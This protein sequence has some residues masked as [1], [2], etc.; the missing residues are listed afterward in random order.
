M[1]KINLNKRTRKRWKRIISFTMAVVMC[2]EVLPLTDL[3]GDLNITSRTAYAYDSSTSETVSIGTVAEFVKY[4]N[5]YESGQHN[6]NDTLVI[7]FGSDST[8]GEFKNGS[9]TYKSIGS[10]RP[11]DGKIIIQETP[12]FTLPCAMFDTITDDVE[13]VDNTGNETTVCLAR[14]ART[15]DEPLFAKHV[16][17]SRTSG[18]TVEWNFKYTGFKE[19]ADDTNSYVFDFAGYIG[20]LGDDL[21][22]GAKVKIGKITHDNLGTNGIANVSATGDAGLV[23]C[24]VKA[25]SELE[26]GEIE[27]TINGTTYNAENNRSSGS[28]TVKSTSSGNAGGLVGSMGVGSTLTLGTALVNHQNSGMDISVTDGYAGG[29]VGFCDDGLITYNNS[30]A[31]TVTQKLTGTDGVGGIAGYFKASSGGTISTGKVS[32]ASG[33]KVNGTGNCGGL[34][35]ELVNGGTM[36][37]SAATAVTSDHNGGAAANLGGLVGKYMAS[38][39]SNTLTVDSSATIT[40]TRSA[41]SADYYGGAIGYLDSADTTNTHSA[42]VKFNGITVSAG[43]IGG[44]T[45]NGYF[46]GL[47]GG[48]PYSFVDLA[49]TN[50]ISYSGISGARNF[51]GIVG[52]LSEG[53]LRLD[54]T[55]NLS[56]AADSS[57]YTAKS[58]QIVGYR[59]CGL[60]YA[61]SDWT[62]TRPSS[63]R[64]LDDVGSWGEVLNC[65]DKL[66]LSKLFTNNNTIGTDHYVTL[67]DA[68]T[69]IKDK[70]DFAKTALNIQLNNGQSTGVLQCSSDSTSATLLASDSLQLEKN[71]TNIELDGTGITGFT[72]DNGADADTAYLTF[73]GTFDG[74]GGTIKLAVGNG[75]YNDYIYRH[76]YNGL[77]AKTSG[78]STIEDLVISGSSVIN[79]RELAGGMNVGNIIAKASGGLTLS[80]VTI[81]SGATI[82]HA[83]TTNS[84]NIG[85]LIGDVT[86][87]GT[88]TISGCEYSGTIT[89]DSSNKDNGSGANIGGLIG[90]VDSNTFTI[91]LTDTDLKGTVASTHTRTEHHI[92]G[93]IGVIKTNANASSGR[94]VNITN[95]KTDGLSVSANGDCGGLL[96]YGWYK[97]D[98]EFVTSNG[99]KVGSTTAPTITNTGTSAAGLCLIATGYWKVNTGGIDID[100]I[101]V[102]ANSATSFGLIINQGYYKQKDETWGDPSS[103]LSSAIYLELAPNAFTV[104]GDTLTLTPATVAVFDELVA[105]TGPDNNVLAN[106]Q[107]V[108]S[109]ATASHALLKMDD[110]NTGVTYQH[111][112]A[113]AGTNASKQY[114]PHSRY[115]YNLDSYRTSPSGNEQNFLMWSVKEY[116]HPSIKDYFSSSYTDTIGSASTDVFNM[117][118]YSYY[119]VDINS[120]KSITIKGK[121][122]LYNTEFNTT[123]NG[124]G[125]KRSSLD[126]TTQHYT[127]HNALFRN[128]NGSLTVQDTELYGKVNVDYTDT[129]AGA[130]VMGTVWSDASG[131]PATVTIKS[132]KLAGIEV[133]NL[134]ATKHSGSGTYTYAPLLI[135]KAG[136]NATITFKNDT[137]G[138]PSIEN[139]SAYSSM[140]AGATTP[141]YIASSL[142]GKMGSTSVQK[143]RLSFEDIKLDGRNSTGVTNLSGL[144]TTY[145][146]KGCLFKEAILLEE[147]CYGDNSGSQGTYNFTYEVD[148]NDSG[149][150]SRCVTYGYEIEGSVE[151][152][153]AQHWYKD[154]WA[155]STTPRYV[156]PDNK[157]NVDS[158]YTDFSTEFMNYVK[159][160]SG[161]TTGYKASENTHELRVNIKA[162]TFSGCGTYND[163]YIITDA[164]DFA[165]IEAIIDGSSTG[166]TIKVPTEITNDNHTATWCSDKTDNSGH[167]VYTTKTVNSTTERTLNTWS[168]AGGTRTITDDTL[169]QYLAGAYY[170]I[171]A[172]SDITI[173]S[174]FTGLSND[175]EAP[176]VFRGVIDGSG[177]TIKTQSAYPLISSSN[178]SV[179]YNLT[180]DVQ[181]TTA[182]KLIETNSKPFVSKGN[183]NSDRC[184][185]YGAVIGQ[186]LGGDNIIDSVSVKFTGQ[187]LDADSK[188]KAQLVPIGGYVGVVVNGGLIFRGVDGTA[189]NNQAGISASNLTN[190]SGGTGGVTSSANTK[191]LYVNPI[192][193]RVLNGYAVTESTSYKP[194]EDGKRKYGDGSGV[195]FDGSSFTE[196]DDIDNYSGTTV[197]VTMRNGT[198][199]YSITDISTSESKLNVTSGRKITADSA[200]AFF[201]MSVIVNS[202]IGM[203]DWNLNGSSLHD[204]GSSTAHT[205]ANGSKSAYD[206]TTTKP[207]MGYY[208]D[209]CMTHHSD[210][211]NIGTAPNTSDPSYTTVNTWDKSGVTSTP[212]IVKKYTVENSE[213]S[214]YYAK[215]IAYSNNTTEITINSGKASNVVYYLP[216]GYKGIGN[217][218][219]AIRYDY[220]D[221]PSG[222]PKTL[223]YYSLYQDLFLYASKFTGYGATISQNTSV[224]YYHKSK[225]L[226][227]Y[228]GAFSDFQTLKD[229]G[230][231]K[232]NNSNASLNAA[233]KVNRTGVGLFNYQPQSA[234]IEKLHLTGNV[235]TDIIQTDGNPYPYTTA[236]YKV[237]TSEW[238]LS[239]GSLIGSASVDQTIK[240]V[241]INNI[242]VEGPKY[243]GGMIGNLP[244]GKITLS[245]DEGYD[246][247][248][249]RVHGGAVTG[250]LIGRNYAG[251][252]TFNFNNKKVDLVEV[253]SRFE[254]I[255]N[256]GLTLND[257]NFYNYGLGGLIGTCRAANNKITLYNANIGSTDQSALSIISCEKA[258]IYT[259]GM[260]G[261]LNRAYLDMQ[262]CTVYNLSIDSNFAAGGIAGHWATSGNTGVSRASNAGKTSIISNVSVVCTLPDATIKSTG[263][264]TK[265]AE[266]KFCTAGGFIGSGKEDMFDVTIQNSNISKYTIEGYGY[267][268]GFVGSWGDNSTYGG[269]GFNDHI[270]ILKNDAI[271]NCMVESKSTT[272]SAGGLLGNLN[273]GHGHDKIGTAPAQDSNNK[274]Y[275]TAANYYLYGYNI[276]TEDVNVIGTNKGAVCGRNGHAPANCIKIAGFTRQGSNAK[277]TENVV[278]KA[279]TATWTSASAVSYANNDN[280]FGTDADSKNGYVVFADYNNAGNK[281]TGTDAEDNPV[282]ANRQ[283]LFSNVLASGSKSNVAYSDRTVDG[284]NVSDNW[285]YVTSSP[286][287]DISNTQYLTSDGAHDSS[288]VGSTAKTILDDMNSAK[289]KRYQN[290][291]FV[292][293]ATEGSDYVNLRDFLTGGMSSFTRHT[294]TGYDGTDFPILVVSNINCN[295]VLTNYLRLLSN[296]NFNYGTDDT[297]NVFNVDISSWKYEGGVFTQ[298]TG[299]DVEPALKRNP[300][301]KGFYITSSEFDNTDYQFSLIDVQYLDPSDTSKIAYHLYVP[302]VVKKMLH[303]NVNIRMSS[304]TTYD[305]DTY[306]SSVYNI[307]EN[308]GNPVT[309]KASFVYIRDK[310]EW[311]AAINEGESVYRNYDGSRK[312]LMFTPSATLFPEGAEIVLLD[313]N[314]DK[315]KSYYGKFAAAT[316]TA[317]EGQDPVYS[318]TNGLMEPAGD[319]IYK[320][321]LSSF[322]GF[323]VCKLNDM[324]TISLDSEATEKNLVIDNSAPDN[325]VVAVINDGSG[326]NGD[327]LRVAEAGDSEGSKVAIKVTSLQD[328]KS[329]IEETYYL[330]IFTKSSTTTNI[331]HYQINGVSDF[332]EQAYPSA[333][334][335][336]EAPHLFLGNIYSNTLTLSETNENDEMSKT[337]TAIGADLVAKVGFTPSAIDAGITGF[338]GNPNVQIFQTFLVSLNMVEKDGNTITNKRGIQ[339]DPACVAS[340]YKLT[341]RNASGI[342]GVLDNN[343]SHLLGCRVSGSYVEILND[344]NLKNDLINAARHP[345]I[346]G[347][348]RDYTV[349]IESSISLTY[350]PTMMSVQFPK[351]SRG[352]GVGT[353]MIGYSNISS[354]STN[355]TASRASVNTETIQTEKSEPLY[356]YLYFMSEI[357]SVDFS[358]KAIEND[359]YLAPNGKYYPVAGKNGNYGQLGIDANQLEGNDTTM[360][361]DTAAYYD[362]SGYSLKS[363]GHYLKIVVQLS[364][365]ADYSQA[366]YIPTYLNN[367]ELYDKDDDD[368][369]STDAGRDITVT[370]PAEE[371][372]DYLYTYIIPIEELDG[373]NDSYVIPIS[374]DV[375][376][377]ANSGFESKT[378]KDMQYSNYRVTVTVGMLETSTGSYLTNSDATDWVVYTNARLISDVIETN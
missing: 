247:D 225:D 228:Y 142:L 61:E 172:S 308:L 356:R 115:Y 270:L 150:D 256:G 351:A 305:P 157:N 311:T 214:K 121:Y 114:N 118:G 67:A 2:L 92:G 328:G 12:I 144:T 171:N 349:Q 297:G 109:V 219:T 145:N 15:V 98:V 158:Q 330:S 22:G 34:F 284:S 170:K 230:T 97:T 13:I 370:K 362:A 194:F 53:V 366:L 223:T 320:L 292:Y 374:F 161:E 331:Y 62:L 169:A 30:A 166:T 85:G 279:Y 165:T 242:K 241:S 376:T 160:Y 329:N 318:Y 31:Y 104:E 324:M 140:G 181:P 58:G 196:V 94:K 336:N 300:A 234:T 112:T 60:V 343:D 255:N 244:A 14:T 323:A 185:Y 232:S 44:V 222:T 353:Y 203:L 90:L 333:R 347:E 39:L 111:K 303:Y 175:V 360:H 64:L 209:Y 28:Y 147:L 78:T 342:E 76:K 23:C 55:T 263:T 295:A 201:L 315:D 127:M 80:N 70:D 191:W 149:T 40:M 239:A 79:T 135:N 11:F 332:G 215:C 312:Y 174:G 138:T 122:S 187:I 167:I 378:G 339:I 41:G 335:N 236:N 69:I 207:R 103:T 231:V 213:N 179:V 18:E 91:N 156:R 113:F 198:K 337:N 89:G 87:A 164:S 216:D 266:K 3:G 65:G 218:Y 151:N 251:A 346:N 101:T 340:G 17:K 52:D 130:L 358:Y 367:F 159:S 74:N 309:I 162:S 32:V 240:S 117:R 293:S 50:V 193:G 224:Y 286:K 265:S 163:P 180:I 371:S 326:N 68:V 183:F 6:P 8:Y 267:A 105:Y 257:A 217:N 96:G 177:S 361:I 119:P 195:V 36:T 277:I 274:G 75:N 9:Q 182:R 199:N 20:V 16:Q 369:S 153:N 25:G 82:N 148:W 95:L 355:A 221:H 377:G 141:T 210:Y 77:F 281:Q 280:L 120:G 287:T 186:I 35:G 192:I 316:N 71:T 350:D 250:G 260:F 66:T 226:S 208:T 63:A 133:D 37:L 46:G 357:T 107:G 184:E 261:I 283:T 108:I 365:K 314:G 123:E 45:E 289:N 298:R 319:G 278:G 285:P 375:Y 100:G 19:T 88:V 313:R 131:S 189:A 155:T 227:D 54:G 190:F 81:S 220:V 273:D 99:L 125:D 59:D 137:A 275:A 237:E 372:G 325:K 246:S 51:G 341:G 188:S 129:G 47:V 154:S 276:Y 252:S 152:S 124:S 291:G 307:A 197:G 354:L 269:C 176:Y 84:Y 304:G 202:G 110:S 368:I 301:T 302:V 73:A 322:D 290:T 363:R 204:V 233:D 139:T 317:G 48:S 83:G 299:E 229:A 178:G 143:L 126:N 21:N 42:Y 235:I 38:A 296:T 238:V 345:I 254:N 49:G 282:Y 272:G 26:I 1:K 102:T 200:Q 93:A 134:G 288:Y 205:N 338:L 310:D 212:Y 359:D 264:Y 43:G 106:G 253:I 364:K 262:N 132:L 373:E 27:V 57:T 344:K 348:E 116:A 33:C 259:G 306:P 206:I 128:V 271:S 72:R 334:T 10:T 249:I 321:K 146:S 7:T 24:T 248:E 327:K 136:S 4:A 86:S 173:P 245:N 352:D 243:T 294:K 268:G 211:L 56:G 168:N 29:I 5:E 258:N